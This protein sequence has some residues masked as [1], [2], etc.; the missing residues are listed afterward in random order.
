MAKR[1]SVLLLLAVIV[2]GAVGA[3]LVWKWDALM[4]KITEKAIV[5]ERQ[6]WL[7]RTRQLEGIITQMQEGQ[8]PGSAIPPERL[9][10]VFGTSSPLVKGS[11]PK[12]MDCRELEESLRAFCQYLD[13]SEIFRTH[14]TTQSCWA[15][16]TEVLASL[17]LHLPTV[18]A[19]S[20]RSANLIENSFYFFRL[21][22]RK[23][24]DL[25]RDILRYEEDLSEPLMG[26]L[27]HWLVLG[28]ECDDP[29][30]SQ[31]SLKV[32][33]QYAGFF[34]Y[35]LGGRSYLCRRDSRIRLLSIYYATLVL[36]EA[37]LRDL[38][39]LGLDIRFFLP[40]IFKEIQSRNDLLYAEEYLQTLSNLQLHYFRR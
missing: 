5:A 39:E 4:E 15:L 11:S 26:I 35:T 6:A 25:I 22:R 18:G 14:G 29:S 40:L 13:S 16:L 12:S 38:N 32:M 31:A 30:Y 27:Y 9:A 1:T 21:L 28:K 2:I 17:E 10:L 33:Y 34:L 36:H 37:N 7:E 19:E 24:I 3:L 23:R 8:E 20:Y